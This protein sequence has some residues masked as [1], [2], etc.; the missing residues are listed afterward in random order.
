MMS[1]YSRQYSSHFLAD[2]VGKF[3]L[4]S[5]RDK[6]FSKLI[7]RTLFAP[8][9]RMYPAGFFTRV[10]CVYQGPPSCLAL[11]FLGDGHCSL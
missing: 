9:H 10:W 1:S 7:F 2:G 6:A 8:A 5:V 3:V 4:Y 11:I